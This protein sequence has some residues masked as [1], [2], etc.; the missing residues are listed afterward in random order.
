[1]SIPQTN[2]V[3]KEFFAGFRHHAHYRD[4]FYYKIIQL[5]PAEVLDIGCG[6]GA[7]LK[8][9]ALDGIFATGVDLSKTA[10]AEVQRQGL[11]ALLVDAN[12]L[13]FED[14]SFDLVVSEY[15]A[16]HMQDIKAVIS[17]A[18]RVCRKGVLFLDMWF[19]QS[20]LSGR[21]AARFDRWCKSID[22]RA[23]EIH[24]RAFTTAELFELFTQIGRLQQCPLFIET[25]TQ[26]ISVP[27]TTDQYMSTID[28]QLAK[29]S[30]DQ[31]TIRELQEI[32]SLIQHHGLYDD[33]V[34]II[35]ALK[36]NQSM[37]LKT[38]LADS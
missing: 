10:I 21:L 28:C 18:M 35:S 38:P 32:K 24:N 23:G 1:M 27:L 11:H 14:N 25:Q 5:E 20:H 29:I 9:L 22:R 3:E 7:L 13:P 6:D 17:E 31:N 37:T 15:S 33:G 16:H 36:I 26:L 19:D 8:R 2:Q 4:S 12:N 34:Q 30:S